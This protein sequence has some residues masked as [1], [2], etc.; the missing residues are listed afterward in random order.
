[1]IRFV[2]LVIFLVAF[3]SPEPIED[4]KICCGVCVESKTMQRDSLCGT[5]REVNEWYYLYTL[6]RQFH[7]E[8]W[9]CNYTKLCQQ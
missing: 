3:C 7:N 4:K 1:M 9:S 5:Y 2:F 6:R 8:D